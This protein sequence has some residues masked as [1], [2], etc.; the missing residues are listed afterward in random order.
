[1]SEH[2][3]PMKIDPVVRCYHN[4]AF[5]L[6]FIQGNAEKLEKDITPWLIGKY[7]NC[8]F[9]EKVYDNKYEI[10]MNDWWGHEEHVIFHQHICMFKHIYIN[11]KIDIL[12]FVKKIIDQECYIS[13]SYNEKY[14]PGKEAYR[15]KDYNHDYLVYGYNDEK[16]VLYSVGY[17]ANRKFVAFE[18]PYQNFI[19]SLFC[20]STEK[21]E[22]N[23]WNYNSEFQFKADYERI[24]RGLNDYIT[25]S[26]SYGT[27][28]G[29][30]Y[31]INANKKLIEFI[32]A[33]ASRPGRNLID[34]RYTRAFFEQKT[35]QNICVQHLCNEKIISLCDKDLK[36]MHEI[37]LKA[38]SIYLL[39]IKYNMS[40][41]KSLLENIVSVYEEIAEIEQL[42]I[43][44]VLSMLP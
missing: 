31:G 34:D 39:V 41:D 5:P 4:L 44:K 16:Q 40:K 19:D 12:Q 26:N 27:H 6:C 24:K 32:Y 2:I 9:D 1:M 22:F 35:I 29:R 33:R 21:L 30:S 37:Y 36:L 25:S 14:I 42:I 43:P 28:D 10:C 18:I 38:N 7:L 23:I 17:L 20:N 8:M 11:L 15:I 3:L 13:G